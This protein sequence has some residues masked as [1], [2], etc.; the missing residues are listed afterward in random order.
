MP[1]DIADQLELDAVLSAPMV[2]DALDRA[3]EKLGAEPTSI[4]DLG[5]G[6][7]TGSIALARRFPT[8][9]VDSLD[10]S[11]DLLHRLT[12][13]AASAG[14]TDRI[15]PHLID[16]DEDWTA[17]VPAG[18]DLIWASLSLHHVTDATKVL[19]QALAALRPGGVLV[20][21]EMTEAPH[22]APT[23][24]GG[25]Q[26]GLAD[27]LVAGL[28]DLGY[29]V[30]ADWSEELSAAGFTSVRRFDHTITAA[31][32]TDDGARYLASHLRSS[33]GR[34]SS[35]L[36]ADDNA[37]LD[38]AV[39]DL[40]TGV[41]RIVMTS[42]RA[43]W[44][45]TRA[46]NSV[47]SSATMDADVVIVGGGPAGLA[48]S[49]ALARSRRSVVVVDAGQPRNAVAHSA[50][51][52]LGNEGVSPL[53]L[54]A[55]GRAEAEAYGVRV[56]S[57]RATGARGSIDDFTIEVDGG[58]TEVQARRVIL[59][60]GLIDDLPEIPGV[61]EGW[62][63]SVLHCPFCHGWEVRDRRIAILTRDEIAI[64]QAVLFRQLSDDVTLFLHEA[65][66][67]THEQSEQ[68]A[69]LNIRVVRP[70]VDRLVL[71][72][73]Q[74]TAVLVDG[75]R[76]FETDAVIVVPG[77]HVRTELFEALGGTAALA[78]TGRQ[79]TADA[80][81]AT[82]VAGVFAAGN[83]AEP[84]AVLAGSMASGVSTG[85]AVHGSLAFADLA[86]AVEEQ[87]TPFSA[88]EEAANARRVV[89]NRGR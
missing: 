81:G 19:E 6:T 46:Q 82:S 85:A 76:R 73:R 37:A 32:G 51:N 56:V 74:V 69:A 33:R 31:G 4:L 49:I 36:T 27:R 65:S 29:P 62:G 7:G 68:L 15:R 20:V 52:V 80:R 40:D 63:E 2:G 22:Y 50:H 3:A 26:D 45:A 14:L 61:R 25:E 58:A 35:V 28:A 10:S 42:G 66:D 79:I 13:S 34:L 67:P 44:V 84:M 11:E 71:D 21:A 1:D 16:L 18:V 57:G 48:A 41:S 60:T 30:T 72:G 88:A 47:R 12:A 39:R 8:A 9:R 78:Q 43:V 38:T 23:D 64:H 55:R 83:A 24:L 89:G 87:R 75:G 53:E 54:Q 59:A 70:R 86:S 17:A 77:Y 5:A